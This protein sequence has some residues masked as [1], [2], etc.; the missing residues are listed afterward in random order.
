ML[1]ISAD[2][3]SLLLRLLWCYS[4]VLQKVNV[5]SIDLAKFLK[6]IVLR[7]WKLGGEMHFKIGFGC[8]RLAG[9]V[10]V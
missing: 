5:L 9:V 7:L 6:I 2:A 10:D 8:G 4:L 3:F 1:V